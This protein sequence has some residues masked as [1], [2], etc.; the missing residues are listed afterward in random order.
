M[1]RTNTFLPFIVAGLLAWSCKLSAQGNASVLLPELPILLSWDDDGVSI[2]TKNPEAVASD[3]LNMLPSSGMDKIGNDF[4]KVNLGSGNI[5]VVI[6]LSDYYRPDSSLYTFNFVDEFEPQVTVEMPKLA[7]DNYNAPHS[8]ILELVNFSSDRRY[9]RQSFLF[10]GIDILHIGAEDCAQVTRTGNITRVKVNKCHNRHLLLRGGL[11]S[12]EEM[13]GKIPALC[14]KYNKRFFGQEEAFVCLED[15]LDDRAAARTQSV[16]KHVRSLITKYNITDFDND[17]VSYLDHLF[18][19]EKGI[20]LNLRAEVGEGG[21]KVK[22]WKK[23]NA[24]VYSSSDS[25]FFF[26]WYDFINLS[27]SKN[28][29]DKQFTVKDPYGNTYM[30]DSKVHFTNV[31]LIQFFNELKSL[32]STEIY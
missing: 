6:D 5:P 24:P 21:S 27:F 23:K 19:T 2:R 22:F 13:A 20:G 4:I 7:L 9:S 29:G 25:Y 8:F 18:L 31:E 28:A 11:L 17:P 12:E 30:Y 26:P 16:W 14:R 3:F 1:K 10:K 32:I 15:C